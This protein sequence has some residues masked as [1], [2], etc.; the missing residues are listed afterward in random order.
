MVFHGRL[1]THWSWLVRQCFIGLILYRIAGKHVVSA[2]FT[3]RAV[4]EQ[5][6]KIVNKR[7]DAV[8][9]LSA[10]ILTPTL[11]E[12]MALI[13]Y[14]RVASNLAAL[15]APPILPKSF[16]D[17]KISRI[18]SES[19]ALVE[20]DPPSAN[21]M[22]DFPVTLPR[23]ISSQ[24][25]S[26]G[27]ISTNRTISCSIEANGYIMCRRVQRRHRNRRSGVSSTGHTLAD[28]WPD[29]TIS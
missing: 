9:D 20:L 16:V 25:K 13:A 8:F 1:F 24:C 18:L 4:S 2:L 6:R 14:V 22:W 21:L 11:E 23:V 10:D 19:S 7:G 15:G 17:R 27:E 5:A 3:D 12:K 26:E 29:A 28:N